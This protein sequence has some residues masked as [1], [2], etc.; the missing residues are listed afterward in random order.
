MKT[1]N[2]ITDKE[3]REFMIQWKKLSREEK[4]E[5]IKNKQPEL[6]HY[7]C[8]VEMEKVDLSIYILTTNKR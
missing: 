6:N 1:K 3:R 5:H 2:T 4:I 8:L 7:D